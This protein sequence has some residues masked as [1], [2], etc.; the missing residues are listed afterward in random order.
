MNWINK[1]KI[2]KSKRLAIRSARSNERGALNIYPIL[3]DFKDI[4]KLFIHF[5]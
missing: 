2:T 4:K 3:A 5:Q 1:I